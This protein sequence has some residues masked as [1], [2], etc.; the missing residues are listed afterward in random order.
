MKCY[1]STIKHGKEIPI[2]VSHMNQCWRTCSRNVCMGISSV[3]IPG[4]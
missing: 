1:E 3:F 2:P 4:P